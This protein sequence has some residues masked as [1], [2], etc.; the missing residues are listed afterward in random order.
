MLRELD[1]VL[2]QPRTL[3]TA[4]SMLSSGKSHLKRKPTLVKVL[5]QLYRVKPGGECDGTSNSS[6]PRYDTHCSL[7]DALQ[8]APEAGTWFEAYF[9]VSVI[10]ILIFSQLMTPFRPSS[11][12]PTHHFKYSANWCWLLLE[13]LVSFHMLAVKKCIVAYIFS[14]MF[15]SN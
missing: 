14:K 8:P 3:E 7:S 5:P 6:S 9:E 10:G 12:M 11:R 1:S 2:D 4:W 15:V 13:H